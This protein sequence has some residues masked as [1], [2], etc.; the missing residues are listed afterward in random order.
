MVDAIENADV[1]QLRRYLR[2]LAD[3]NEIVDLASR[4]GLWLDEKRFDE[5]GTVFTEDVEVQTLGGASQGIVGVADQARRNHIDFE[6]TQHVITDVLVDLDGDRATVGANLVVT[7]VRRAD[8]PEQHFVLGERYH[9]EAVRTPQGWR[10]SRMRISP[11]WNAGS[12]D[13]ISP[14]QATSPESNGN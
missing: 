8:A 4:L 3:R 7:F 10:F 13:E 11:V 14:A 12:R 1:A 2:E 5:A 6:R 9:F